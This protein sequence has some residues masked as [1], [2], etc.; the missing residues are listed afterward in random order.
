MLILDLWG[1]SFH[2][3]VVF[4]LGKDLLF[5]SILGHGEMTIKRNYG[6]LNFKEQNTLER[7][8]GNLRTNSKKGPTK[9]NDI[10]QT[11]VGLKNEKKIQTLFF[12]KGQF[13]L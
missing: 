6:G 2:A 8:S 5:K 4:G 10:P 11:K 12:S 1:I 13:W 7:F 9:M 3:V